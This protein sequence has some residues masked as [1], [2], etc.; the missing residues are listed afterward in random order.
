MLLI[1]RVAPLMEMKNLYNILSVE[2]KMLF[3][4]KKIQCETNK[5]IEKKDI[6][7]DNPEKLVDKIPNKTKIIVSFSIFLE[8]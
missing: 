6:H 2:I 5:L 4:K 7:P 3:K 8:E 1:R